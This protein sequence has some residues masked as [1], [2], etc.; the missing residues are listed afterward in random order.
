LQKRVTLHS[1]N[2]MTVKVYSPWN[3]VMRVSIVG[4]DN[5]LP[6]I[7]A[8]IQPSPNGAGWNK[9]LTVVGFTCTDPTS[10]IDACTSPVTLYSDTAGQTVVGTAIDK[11]GNKTTKSVLVKLDKT[12][13]DISAAVSPQ[14]NSRGWNNS[15]V[16]VTFTATDGLSGV[17]SVSGPVALSAEGALLTARGTATDVA[18]NSDSKIVGLR[19]DKTAPL[20]TIASPQNNAEQWSPWL[21]LK[22]TA[23]DSL[24]GLSTVKCDGLPAYVSSGEFICLVK[25]DPGPNTVNVVATDAAGNSTTESRTVTYMIVTVSPGQVTL[26]AGQ[27]QQFTPTSRSPG[28]QA[29]AASVRAAYTPR[30]PAWH[31]NSRLP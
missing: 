15:D 27:T 8:S 7:T 2:Y 19:I 13:P 18:G 1:I 3:G 29:S 23:T 9:S 16:T 14:P 17:A 24:S 22:G 20:V 31:R 25:L 26:Y 10:G 5:D 21:T 6:S 30:R 12:D 11:A 4:V 28:R